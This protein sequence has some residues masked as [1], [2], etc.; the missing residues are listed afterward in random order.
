MRR[1]ER[2]EKRRRGKTINPILVSRYYKR[3]GTIGVLRTTNISLH[4]QTNSIFLSSPDRCWIF[5]HESVIA[6]GMDHQGK[7][8]REK[9][10]LVDGKHLHK[11]NRIPSSCRPQEKF[12]WITNIHIPFILNEVPPPLFSRSFPNCPSL[13]ALLL[14]SLQCYPLLKDK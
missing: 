2:E 12:L 11:N 8:A 10:I 1:E 5:P 3:H 14:S 9:K 13:S 6:K 4:K 7:N